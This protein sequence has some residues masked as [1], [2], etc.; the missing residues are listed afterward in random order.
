[1]LHMF[2]NLVLWVSNK[3]PDYNYL[4]YHMSCMN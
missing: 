1:M 4:S 3:H 2:Q